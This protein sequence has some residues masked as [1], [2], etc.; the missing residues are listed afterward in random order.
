MDIALVEKAFHNHWLK[1]F[2]KLKGV[3]GVYHVK[4]VTNPPKFLL[5]TTVDDGKERKVIRYKLNMQP[6]LESEGEYQFILNDLKK[7][8]YGK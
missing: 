2:K 7:R 5:A 6:S 1:A 3:K 4:T 8:G